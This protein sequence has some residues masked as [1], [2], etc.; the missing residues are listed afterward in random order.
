MTQ[1]T[2]WK[3][4]ALVIGYPVEKDARQVNNASINA[5]VQGGVG[6]MPR[7]MIQCVASIGPFTHPL[8]GLTLPYPCTTSNY[9]KAST[10][11]RAVPGIA[12]RVTTRASAKIAAHASRLLVGNNFPARW[13]DSLALLSLRK[14]GTAHSPQDV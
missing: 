1:V 11:L 3:P 13:R 12:K 8:C 10:R 5:K 2:Q 6:G 7:I 4:V 9:P 14:Q